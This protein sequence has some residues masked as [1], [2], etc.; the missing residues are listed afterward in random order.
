MLE[1]QHILQRFFIFLAI[2]EKSLE[3]M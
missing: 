2:Y 3:K 1:S